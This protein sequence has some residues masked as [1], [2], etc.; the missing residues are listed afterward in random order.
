MKT[1]INV[2]LI[3]DDKDDQFFFAAALGKI[4]DASFH[5]VANN[6]KEALELLRT[7]DILPD[8]IFTDINMPVM[9]GLKFL[10]EVKKDPRLQHIP[11]I[12]VSV[13]SS[14]NGIARQLGARGFITKP[15]TVDR[16]REELVLVMD[17][18][19]EVYHL[20]PIQIYQALHVVPIW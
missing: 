19:S 2:L 13:A 11:V 6:G 18:D 14:C 1:P 20:T 15:I 8:M 16:L 4:E 17:L 9:D 10:M 3:E 5:S 7:A 12:I